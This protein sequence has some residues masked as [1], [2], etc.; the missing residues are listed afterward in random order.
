MQVTGCSIALPIDTTPAPVHCGVSCYLLMWICT[1]DGFLS[2]V[3]D[4]DDPAGDR[5]LVRSRTQLHLLRHFPHAKIS[6]GEGTDYRWRAWIDRDEVLNCMEVLVEGIDYPNFKNRAHEQH[7]HGDEHHYHQAL[8]NV[9]GCM[10]DLQ[11]RTDMD[12]KKMPL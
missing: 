7:P 10:R 9:W 12:D 1:P 2:I 5:L 4:K 3:A 11:D 6:E 8:M